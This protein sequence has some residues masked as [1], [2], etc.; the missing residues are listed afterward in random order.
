MEKEIKTI[1]EYIEQFPIE[2]KEI[3]QKLRKTILENLP[4]GFEET[5]SYGMIGYVV[6]HRI[7]PDGYHINSQ[8]P[9]PFINIA[10]Q[11][12]H[13]AIYH[14]ALYADENLLNW[15]KQ[16]YAK[17]SQAKPDI[18][19]SCIRFKKTEQIPFLLIGK[20]VKKIKVQQWIKL[21]ESSVKK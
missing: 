14:M 16:E 3:L 6:P 4:T 18:G 21:Y 13:I 11:K 1:N 20:L 17:H 19:K 8:L 9:L 5:I 7:Y 10:S 15:F 2:R 12:S